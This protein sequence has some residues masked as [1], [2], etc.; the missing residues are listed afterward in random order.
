MH[1]FLL[2]LSCGLMLL[3]APTIR[4]HAAEGDAKKDSEANKKS[5]ARIG[6]IELSGSYPE[7]AGT[8]GLF[9]E[10]QPSL[11]R[12]FERLDQADSR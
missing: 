10:V 12:L 8:A 6:V 5:S 3:V 11:S 7:G 4:V 9:S 2:G 1:R